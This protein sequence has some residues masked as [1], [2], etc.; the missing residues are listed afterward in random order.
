MIRR[1]PRS[2]QA[3]TLFPYTTLFRSPSTAWS[4]TADLLALVDALAVRDAPHIVG[5]SIGGGIAIDFALE[6]PDRVSKLVL[7]GAGVGGLVV[8]E[9]NDPIEAEVRAAGE[10]GDVDVYK[11][12]LVINSVRI[13]P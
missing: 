2:T 3:F 5:C 10:S 8:G 6:H 12:A 11:T 9:E 1:P 13:A 7:V 4:P